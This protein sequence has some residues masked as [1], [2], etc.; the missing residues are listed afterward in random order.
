MIRNQYNDKRERIGYWE[1]YLDSGNPWYKGN[2][3]NGIQDGY[4]EVY[5]DSGN[6]WY[7][8]NYDNGIQD[9]YWE[10]YIENKVYKE[11]YFI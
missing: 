6:P 5:W 10:F 1:V 2:Y 9:G 3:D 4:W 8:G 7:K 11:A